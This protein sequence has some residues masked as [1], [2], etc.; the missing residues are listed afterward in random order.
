M[1]DFVNF[2][3]EYFFKNK[4][5]LLLFVVMPWFYYIEL[6]LDVHFCKKKEEATQLIDTEL[7]NQIIPID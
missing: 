5:L 6:Y 2:Q 7:K 3:G 1:F 4:I